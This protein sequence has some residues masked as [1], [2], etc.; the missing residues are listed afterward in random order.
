M[1]PLPLP[2][3]GKPFPFN[4]LDFGFID[5]LIK[6]V[7]EITP[8]GLMELANRYLDTDSMDVSISGSQK[9]KGYKE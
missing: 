8:A 2:K 1:V 3:V 7:N 6:T 4:N 9:P 5:R